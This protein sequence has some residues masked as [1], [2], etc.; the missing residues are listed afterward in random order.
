MAVTID[1][2]GQ[3][4][5]VTGGA[6]GLGFAISE[7]FGRAGAIIAL[8]DLSPERVDRAVVDLSAAGI[9][10][11]GYAADVRDANAVRGMVDRVV[12]ELG[13]PATAVANAGIYPN[14]P[15]LDLSEEEW[16]RVIDINVKGV[17]LTCQ[18]VA[19]AM[20]AANRG[21]QLVA[22]S[23]GAANTALWGWSHYCASKAAVVMLTKAMA[24][25]LGGHGIR[26]NA[27]LPGYIDVPE[28]GEHLDEA[29]KSAARTAIPIGRSGEPADIA[30]AVLMLA[31][32]LAG[33]VSGAA[34][35]VDGGSSAGRF[36][37]RPI[38]EPGTAG[39]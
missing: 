27:V 9:A 11:R 37:V 12:S 28:G 31:S 24:L 30:R 4:V 20:V 15:F 29:Y 8:N 2:S 32:P 1:F 26:V 38:A 34:L 13:V 7:A 23:S 17:F 33:Y 18:T 35:A 19:R 21:G 16:D 14:T 25:E 36:G 10:C 22:I 6:T 5:L 39:F 3:V